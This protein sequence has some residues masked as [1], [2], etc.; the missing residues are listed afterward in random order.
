[1]F[2]ALSRDDFYGLL[3][4]GDISRRPS[5]YGPRCFVLL[6]PALWTE[7]PY[8]LLIHDIKR[9]RLFAPRYQNLPMTEFMTEILTWLEES[10]SSGKILHEN[11]K[12]IRNQDRNPRSRKRKYVVYRAIIYRYSGQVQYL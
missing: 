8:T 5:H 7:R 10:V 4:G 11:N 6:T 1:M 2:P 12:P 3:L 9:R